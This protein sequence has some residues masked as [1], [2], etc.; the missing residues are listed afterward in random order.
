[1]PSK[2]HGGKKGTRQ[3]PRLRWAEA[4]KRNP[5]GKFLKSD[6]GRKAMKKAGIKAM[7]S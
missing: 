5:I 4:G 3:S 7:F 1:M 6:R 2:R